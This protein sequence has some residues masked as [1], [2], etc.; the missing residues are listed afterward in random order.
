LS[1]QTAVRIAPGDLAAPVAVGAHRRAAAR[2]KKIQ[3]RPGSDS[4]HA[5]FR[6]AQHEL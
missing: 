6:L 4:G 3:S 5:G 1:E 2:P